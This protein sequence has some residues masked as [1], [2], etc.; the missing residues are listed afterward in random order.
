MASRSAPP[1]GGAISPCDGPIRIVVATA[2]R[3][4]EVEPRSGM[5]RPTT[6]GGS[7]D[8][9]LVPNHLPGALSVPTCVSQ[10]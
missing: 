10:S 1:A 8:L 9:S 5:R 2:H 6:D 7:P 3:V 4:V